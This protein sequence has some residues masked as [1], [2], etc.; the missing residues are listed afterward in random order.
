MGH[1]QH[2]IPSLCKAAR[3][4]QSYM[5][6]F[7]LDKTKSIEQLENDIWSDSNFPTTLVE[8]CYHFRK[9]AIKDLSVEQFRL[10]IGQNIGLT[11][12][13]PSA[14]EILR[15]NILSAGNFYE[16]DLLSAVLSSEN[17][18]WL[19]NPEIRMALTTL[20]SEKRVEISKANKKLLQSVDD[21]MLS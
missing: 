6:H 1:R 10:L 8:K 18:Y 20:L 9:L 12:L 16:G 17:S 19:A 2:Q 21:F 14:V 11:F 13:I 5:K 4:M 15:E 7:M 3:C